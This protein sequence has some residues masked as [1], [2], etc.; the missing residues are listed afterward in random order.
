[1][2]LSSTSAEARI[3][4]EIS[5]HLLEPPIVATLL[6]LLLGLTPFRALAAHSLVVYG[7]ANDLLVEAQVA[8]I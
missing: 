1:M 5:N 7:W 6:G 2:N 8:A 4:R 3:T